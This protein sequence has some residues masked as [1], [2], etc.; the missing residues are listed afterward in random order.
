MS[1]PPR[2]R[3]MAVLATPPL[4]TSG[5]R[6]LARVRIAANLIGSTS[7]SVSNLLDVATNDVREIAKVGAREE[8]WVKSRA[9]LSTAI[10]DADAVLLA[11]GTE[12]VGSARQHHRDQV[13]WLL[14]AI[15]AQRIPSWTVGGQSRHPSRWQRYTSRAHAGLDFRIALELS[16]CQVMPVTRIADQ[17]AQ[18]V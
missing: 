5:E 6:T 18:P 8:P 1:L 4:A 13:A 14:D 17:A 10:G 9:A 12:P 15:R 7:V 2:L 16:L 3:L 11:W